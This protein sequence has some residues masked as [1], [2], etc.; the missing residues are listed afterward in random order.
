M[1]DQKKYLRELARETYNYATS[2][3]MDSRRAAWTKHNDLNW[4]GKPLLYIRSIPFHEILLAKDLK[5][6]TPVLRRLEREFLLNRYRM[7]L[8]DDYIIEPYININAAVARSKD[9]LWGIP[10]SLSGHHVGPAGAKS[11]NP[12][13]LE[14]EDVKKMYVTDY[15]VDELE[16]QKKFDT[17]YDLLGDSIPIAVNRATPFAGPWEADICTM[18]T[19][20]RGLEQLMIDFYDDPEWLHDLLAFMRDSILRQLDLTEQAGGFS[21]INTINQAM[22]YSTGLANRSKIEPVNSTKDLWIFTAAQE[23]TGV[24]PAMFKEFLFDYQKPIT[25]KFGL[26]SYGCCEDMTQKIDIIKTLKN[27]RRIAVTPFSN[28]QKCAE[29]I[30]SDY[31]VS[32]RPHP[33]DA[34]TYGFDETRTR[35]TM[36]ENFKIFRDNHCTFDITLKDAHTIGKDP[37]AIDKWTKVVR[38]EIENF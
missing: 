16:T 20:M 32:W 10:C 31:V 29:Q 11:F 37:A 34:V 18:L 3:I 33:A 12:S 28:T 7:S 6:D 26:A 24:G 27:L 35:N 4:S 19:Q 30:G 36:R 1:L 8:P 17:M 13:I 2:D 21:S 25:E 9:S 15:T 38:E 14:L 23:Y 5:C 22:P